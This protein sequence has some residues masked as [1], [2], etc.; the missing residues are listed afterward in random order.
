MVPKLTQTVPNV[1]KT[2]PN[3]PKQSPKQFQTRTQTVPNNPKQS[4]AST[5]TVANSSKHY[6]EHDEQF[7]LCIWGKSI[8]RGYKRKSPSAS[9]KTAGFFSIWYDRISTYPGG[10]E[11]FRSIAA[12]VGEGE[13][14][15]HFYAGCKE[16]NEGWFALRCI[17]IPEGNCA[18]P[19]YAQTPLVKSSRSKA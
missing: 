18:S 15:D 4:Q 8:N 5:Q 2:I 3:C 1:S 17:I 14:F 16:V 12:N 10:P 9:L 6:E 13:A 11:L 7:G 19:P